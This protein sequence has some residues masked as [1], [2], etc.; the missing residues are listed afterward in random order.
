M[1]KVILIFD[2][3]FL[4][5]EVGVKLTPPP[6]EKTTLKKPGCNG[7]RSATLL[8]GQPSTGKFLGTFQNFQSSFKEHL[9][10]F[11]L[12]NDLFLFYSH[13]RCKANVFSF[14]L[15][16]LREVIC[17]SKVIIWKYWNSYF[18][19]HTFWLFFFHHRHNSI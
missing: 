8:K 2:K 19:F 17:F 5:Y 14:P 4:K 18:E 15:W 3:F 11:R 12:P 10:S 9:L 7:L 1:Y 13:I 16:V 6:P